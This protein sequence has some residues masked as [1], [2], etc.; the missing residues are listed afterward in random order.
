M[1]RMP[2]WCSLLGPVDQGSSAALCADC[3][4]P[5]TAAPLATIVLLAQ[6]ND[7]RSIQPLCVFEFIA[8]IGL[9]GIALSFFH[10]TY[11][12]LHIRSE[13]RLCLV[14]AALRPHHCHP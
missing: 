1:L 8:F 2:A 11:R 10:R 9:R 13:R 3:L 4:I 12:S 6:V 14:Q 5:L 7:S